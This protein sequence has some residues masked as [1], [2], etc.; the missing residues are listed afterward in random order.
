MRP[1]LLAPLVTAAAVLAGCG[2]QPSPQPPAVTR[3]PHDGSTIRLPGE[4][5]FVELV[6]E[7]EVDARQ[8]GAATS[9]VAYFLQADGKSP[10]SPA[11]TDVKFEVGSEAKKAG[12]S[13]SLAAEPKSGDPAGA[14]R[15]ASRP[16]P[17]SLDSLRGRLTAT[18]DG[19]P[20]S[21]ELHGGR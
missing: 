10:L 3:G 1:R 15:F 20:V 14:A 18:L 6:N 7:P 16:G 8:R 17:F 13:V 19:Q 21:V 5:G 12:Q 4:K 9:V 2:S 11:P